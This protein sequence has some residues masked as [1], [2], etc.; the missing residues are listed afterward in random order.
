MVLTRSASGVDVPPPPTPSRSRASTPSTARKP[1]TRKVTPRQSTLASLSPSPPSS[2]PPTPIAPPSPPAHTSA[3]P[4]WSHSPS[5]LALFWL[6]VS[7]PLVIWDCG[8][9]L[10]RPHS[11]PGGSLHWPIWQPYALYGEVDHVYGRRQWDAHD[12]FGAAQAVLNVVETALYLGYIGIWSRCRKTDSTS[13]GVVQTVQTVGG[14]AGAR[15]LLMLF[16]AAVMTLSKT[17]LYWLNE[18]F[19]GFANIGHNDIVSLVFLWIIPNGLWIVFPAIMTY[20]T[21]SEIVTALAGL[22]RPDAKKE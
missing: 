20:K 9:V 19:S 7:L 12:G 22:P 6:A 15:A 5:G 11:M 8:Y 4:L 2:L 16:A 13:D 14:R 10:L 21:G 3:P 1:S 17:V 18:Y